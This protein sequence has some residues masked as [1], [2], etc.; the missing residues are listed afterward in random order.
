MLY[1]RNLPFLSGDQLDFEQE[2][3]NQSAA[4]FTL[5]V[6]GNGEVNTAWRC[7]HEVLARLT[8]EG[9]AV[10]TDLTA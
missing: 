2:P 4:W 1:M 6:W 9:E 3:Y 10:G 5:F 7:S 8:L